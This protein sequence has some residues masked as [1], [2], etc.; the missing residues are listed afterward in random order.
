MK[1]NYEK[2]S[3]YMYKQCKETLVLFKSNKISIQ[4]NNKLNVKTNTKE[5]FQ[6]LV[7]DRLHILNHINGDKV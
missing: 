4:N 1:E 3:D 6:I 2:I 7:N 5:N